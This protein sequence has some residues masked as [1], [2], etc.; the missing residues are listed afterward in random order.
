MSFFALR[1]Q[2]KIG[3]KNGTFTLVARAVAPFVVRFWYIGVPL[4]FLSKVPVF[5]L[6]NHSG[7]HSAP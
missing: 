1:P 6:G 7:W 3:V 4:I 2:G 5:S